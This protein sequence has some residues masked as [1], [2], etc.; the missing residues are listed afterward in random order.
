MAATKWNSTSKYWQNIVFDYALRAMTNAERAAYKERVAAWQRA[1]P[2]LQEVRD[3]D[4]RAAN[5]QQAMHAFTGLAVWA[6]RGYPAPPTS[7]LIEQQRWF[8]KLHRA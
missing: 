4:I 1:A 3:A 8:K 7:G 5:T 6:V 2:V